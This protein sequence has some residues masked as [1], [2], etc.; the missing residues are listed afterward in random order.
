LAAPTERAKSAVEG[1]LKAIEKQIGQLDKQIET[2]APTGPMREY[3]FAMLQRQNRGE[4]PVPF[5][6]W[7]PAQERKDAAT[8]RGAQPDEVSSLRKEVQGLPS[9]KNVAQA[10]PV[11]KSMLDAAGRDDRASD[12]NLIYGMA[13][14]MD[15]GSVVRESEM[16]VAQAIATLPQQIQQNIK[17]Q[18]GQT[19]RLSK[20]V[21]EGIMREAYSRMSSYNALFAQDSEQYR[22]IATR[23]KMDLADVIPSF[24]EFKPYEPPEAKAKSGANG[25]TAPGNAAMRTVPEQYIRPDGSSPP[26]PS[27]APPR[28]ALTKADWEKLAP[29][30]LYIDARGDTRRKGGN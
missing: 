27:A 1:R 2:Y 11:Y 9:Y 24:G 16:T 26:M 25:S 30:E 10:A 17:S 29:G 21:R 3:T 13:K 14:L 8:A 4:A 18:L 19:G 7:D 12:V 5:E 22:G 15:P 20:D 28:K 23:R 6:Q